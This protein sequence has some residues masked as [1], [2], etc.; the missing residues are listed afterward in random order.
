MNIKA[1]VGRPREFDEDEVMEK[2]MNL[3]W[4][5]GYEGTGLSDIMKSTGLQKGSLYKAWGSKHGMY[6]RALAHY[7]RMAVDGA[8]TLLTSERPP[9]ERITDFLSIP[10][11]A[12]WDNQDWRGCF[13]CNASAD[14]AALDEETRNLVQRGYGKMGRA[15]AGAVTA[16]QPD[17]AEDK[18]TQTAQHLLAV[19]SG[20]RVMARSAMPRA[21][22]ENA[23]EAALSTLRT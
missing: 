7:D 5:Q 18:V 17:W 14:H 1:S 12:A 11:I 22:L 15:L 13:L 4:E 2:I 9:F 10:I 3:F 6:I 21:T 23:R 20:L 19:Y 16:L 8:V